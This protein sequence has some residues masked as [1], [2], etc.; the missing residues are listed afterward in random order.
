MCVPPGLCL[1]T[2]SKVQ[3]S[4]VSLVPSRSIHWQKH[5]CSHRF[6]VISTKSISLLLQLSHLTVFTLHFI[7]PTGACNCLLFPHS[8]VSCFG[9]LDYS[10][11]EAGSWLLPSSSFPAMCSLFLWAGKHLP[12][13]E[14]S[15]WVGGERRAEVSLAGQSGGWLRINI[16]WLT[17]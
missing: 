2:A 14:H 1:V 5:M 8:L 6:S 11:P 4:E 15:Q 10:R 17:Q 16:M 13:R 7:F 12:F 9:N 3:A